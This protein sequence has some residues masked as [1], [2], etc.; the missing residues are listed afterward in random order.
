MNKMQKIGRFMADKLENIKANG[1][2]LVVAAVTLGLASVA[3]AAEGDDPVVQ[4]FESAFTTI[5]DNMV[6]LLPLAIGVF[7]VPV[8]VRF[9][10]KMIG[11][12]K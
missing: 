3:S 1:T 4:Q 2:R 5:K 6:Y 11:A 10:K 7:L 8:G 12:A 9:L